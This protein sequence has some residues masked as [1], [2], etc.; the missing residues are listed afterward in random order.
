MQDQLKSIPKIIKL[1]PK[2]TKEIWNQP[3]L[4]FWE[5]R[6]G[7]TKLDL[8]GAFFYLKEN[9]FYCTLRYQKGSAGSGYPSKWKWKWKFILAKKSDD[10][11][12]IIFFQQVARARAR[13][14]S[15]C[16]NCRG[17]T[18]SFSWKNATL[19]FLV[20]FS[21]SFSTSNAILKAVSSQEP[22]LK[23]NRSHVPIKMLSHSTKYLK[24]NVLK[25]NFWSKITLNHKKALNLLWFLVKSWVSKRSFVNIL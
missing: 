21:F 17:E 16:C 10:V 3:I 9:S 8:C 19:F 12:A 6:G 20:I 7:V 13:P 1:N 2:Y 11:S 22:R 4:T 25:L 14:F 18:K 23:I 5:V 24:T 15:R